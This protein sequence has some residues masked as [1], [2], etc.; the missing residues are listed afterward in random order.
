MKKTAFFLGIIILIISFIVNLKNYKSISVNIGKT[1]NVVLTNATEIPYYIS[2]ERCLK[3]YE[4]LNKCLLG[5]YILA[6]DYSNKN[7]NKF[8]TMTETSHCFYMYTLKANATFPHKWVKM[9]ISQGKL[10]FIVIV[11]P[12]NDKLNLSN[13]SNLSKELGKYTSPSFVGIYP[14]PSATIE[15]AKEFKNFFEKSVTFFNINSPNTSIVWLCGEDL[16]MD[17]P[18]FSECADWVGLYSYKK[19]YENYISKNNFEKFYEAFQ[20]NYP[21]MVLVGISHYNQKTCKYYT[22]Q[23]Q[24]ELSEF[25]KNIK[26]N[27]PCV[28]AICYMNF[29]GKNFLNNY[30]INDTDEMLI[31]YKSS[32]NDIYFSDKIENNSGTTTIYIKQKFNLMQYKGKIYFP[33][34]Y[35]FKNCNKY[36]IIYINKEKYIPLERINEVYQ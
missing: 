14:N 32:L 34:K 5:A 3:K 18:Y 7:I 22:F 9:C 20:E 21:I 2:K 24:T 28:K 25:Y 11:P 8:E 35:C 27:Y 30:L 19:N 6:D 23:A 10:P 15:N 12:E 1:K 4:P 29:G 13:I 16:N 33:L 26:E 36:D 31:S 17:I